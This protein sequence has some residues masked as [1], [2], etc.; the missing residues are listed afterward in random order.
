[1]CL[2]LYQVLEEKIRESMTNYH[3]F[4]ERLDVVLRSLDARQVSDF[5][6]AEGQWEDGP[7]KDVDFAMWMMIASSKTLKDLHPQAHAWLMSH[8]H[9]N[10]AQAAFAA[11]SAS[12]RKGSQNSR[13]AKS[14]GGAQRFAPN[15]TR[16]SDIH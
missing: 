11:G 5:L 8:G 2:G 10:E 4:R 7:P 16:R 9:V 15:K 3:N 6:V 12:D 14:G 1:M 13:S